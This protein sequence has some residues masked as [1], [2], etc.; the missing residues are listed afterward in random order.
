VD[1]T[2]RA[3]LELVRIGVIQPHCPRRARWPETPS[4]LIDP[5]TLHAKGGRSAQRGVTG[6]RK[7]SRH[8][9]STCPKEAAEKKGGFAVC[10]P[11]Q[12]LQIFGSAGGIRGERSGAKGKRGWSCRPWPDRSRKHVR[13]ISFCAK[14]ANSEGIKPIIGLEAY[15]VEDRHQKKFTRDNRDKRYQ[16]IFLAKNMDGYRNL[17]EMCSLGFIEGYYYKFPRID[18]ELVEKYRE[19]VIATYRWV[20]RERSRPDSEPG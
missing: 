9:R 7:M 6:E 17:A 10:T 12:S 1:A 18:R 13:N 14:A 2:A 15:F 8:Q 3:F 5:V 16:Q 19:G 11:A 20:C 4:E